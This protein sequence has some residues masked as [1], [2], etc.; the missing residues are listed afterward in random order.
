MWLSIGSLE[1]RIARGWITQTVTVRINRNPQSPLFPSWAFAGT[2][3]RPK[4]QRQHGA[5]VYPKSKPIAP[6]STTKLT[7]PNQKASHIPISTP[8]PPPCPFPCPIPRPPNRHHTPT[9][10]LRYHFV[11]STRVHP[12]LRHRYPAR[13][14]PAPPPPP[15]WHPSRM[16]LLRLLTLEKVFAQPAYWQRRRGG[17]WGWEPSECEVCGGL[18]GGCQSSS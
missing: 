7:P 13:R 4:R 8:H 12:S 17:C 9:C 16:C 1:F 18:G 14:S 5:V 2:Q 11:V 6:R 3:A 10:V 15:R